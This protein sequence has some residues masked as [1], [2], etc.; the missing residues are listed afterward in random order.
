MPK[1]T[2]DAKGKRQKTGAAAAQIDDDFD[3]MLAE[4]CAADLA[5]PAAGS[6]IKSQSSSSSG[7][8]SSSSNPTPTTRRWSKRQ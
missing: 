6:T 4:V 7:S 3:D 2:K 8:G 5:P 1:Q